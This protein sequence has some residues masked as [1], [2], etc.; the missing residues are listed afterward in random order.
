MRRIPTIGLAILVVA[1]SFGCTPA[2][3][4]F[5]PE[6]P[7]LPELP[8]GLDASALNVPEDNPLTPAKVALGWQLYYDTRLSVDGSVSCATCHSPEFG[9][10][11][12]RHVSTGISGYQGGRNSPTVINAAF[13]ATQ[14]WDGRAASL[15]EQALGPIENPVEMGNTVER[16]VETLSG[17]D[18]YQRQFAAVFGRSTIT[19]EMVGKAIA[20]FERT[21]LSG[22]SDW[23][24]WLATH[25]ES[26]ISESARRGEVLFRGKAGCA[27][28]HLGFNFTDATFD[29][30]HNIGIGMHLS[31][32]DLG[33]YEVTG[34]DADRGAFKTPTMRNIT[35]T[36]PYMHGGRVA[37][38]E[39]V[40]DIY[41]QG[42]MPNEWLDPK[43]SPLN[44]TDEEKA[45]LLAFM[46]ALTGEL[47]EFTLRAPRLPPDPDEES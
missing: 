30:Y 36:A 3:K 45:D 38:L 17:I 25:D 42:G 11:D 4:L 31:D 33:R 8:L 27:Q 13:S 35:Q 5:E 34:V 39:E 7:N 9:F 37:T 22:N 24:R 40:I 41:D 43:M 29:L 12:Q 16:V 6:I 46:E 28:C 47:P 20:A 32:P 23:D 21:V 15:E 14:F 19:P 10:A 2:E 1:F 26:V 18:G 44:L